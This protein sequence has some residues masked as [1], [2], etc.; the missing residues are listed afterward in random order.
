M[1]RSVL[2]MLMSVLILLTACRTTPPAIR[3]SFELDVTVSGGAIDCT[4]HLSRNPAAVAVTITAPDSVAGI[5]YTCAAGE[6]QTSYGDMNCITGDDSLPTSG[7]PAM[8]CAVLSRIGEAAYE[9]SDDSDD[10]YR[11][12]LD[13]G[14]AVIVCRDG[15]P[16]MITA[17]FSPYTVTATQ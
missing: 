9:D 6:L 14:D 16:R 1:K 7:A 11:L 5:T 8:L 15:I 10:V 12:H 3:D 2:I 17:D 4:A 13:Q